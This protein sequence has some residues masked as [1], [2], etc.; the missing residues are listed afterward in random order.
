MKH[1]NPGDHDVIQ[2]FEPAVQHLMPTYA[3]ESDMYEAL[4]VCGLTQRQVFDELDR[5]FGDRQNAMDEL[6][7]SNHIQ[8]ILFDAFDEAIAN[9]TAHKAPLYE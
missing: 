2:L 6:E 3:N 1:H 9:V 7:L 4:N 5:R 8:V